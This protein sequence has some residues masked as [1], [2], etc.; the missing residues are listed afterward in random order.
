MLNVLCS[1]QL[2]LSVVQTLLRAAEVLLS[3]GQD[4][5]PLITLDAL[6]CLVGSR[7]GGTQEDASRTTAW[8]QSE[9]ALIP[10]LTQPLQAA[11]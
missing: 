10:W 4:V 5:S 3:P 7:Q 11:S 6:E 9:G 8:P 2:I 1:C